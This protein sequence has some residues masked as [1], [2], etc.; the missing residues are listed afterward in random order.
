VA[1]DEMAAEPI[2]NT[3]RAFEVDSVAN[4]LHSQVRAS[5][6][7][8]SDLEIETVADS[9][10]DGQAAAVNSNALTYFK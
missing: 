1:L 7:L 3:E 10:N 5:Q 8:G 9:G 2:A 6:C 4:C